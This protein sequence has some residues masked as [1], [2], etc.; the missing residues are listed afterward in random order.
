MR[1][2]RQPQL[3]FVMISLNCFK[4]LKPHK[5]QEKHSK[6]GYK[7][8]L[9]RRLLYAAELRARFAAFAATHRR[10][11]ASGRKV[12]AGEVRRFFSLALMETVVQTTG[13]GSG[14]QGSAMGFPVW[15][16]SSR[17]PAS[18]NCW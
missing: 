14:S 18:A 1:L 16:S 11:P 9:R 10:I 6:Y 8:R 5:T 3:W 7:N 15:N 13:M 4:T 2:S 17:L 12:V